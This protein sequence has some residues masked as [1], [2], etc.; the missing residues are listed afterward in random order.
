MNSD[1]KNRVCP[2]EFAGGLDI[3]IR[4]LFHDPMRILRPY[5]SEGMAVLDL[6]CGPGFF[7]MDM[8]K[9]TGVS[10]KV[11]AADLQD[12][13]LEMLKRKIKCAGLKNIEPYKTPKGRIG[14]AEKFDFI[15]IFYVLHEIP[16]QMALLKE[17]K[18]MLKPDGK[19]L[20]VE[21][22]VHV[23]KKD[24]N[25]SIGTMKDIGFNIIEE[26]KIWFSRSV[27]VSNNILT[28]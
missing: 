16:D 24:F 8:A 6:G 18:T 5:I 4:R 25:V 2:I 13:M 7:T 10:G 17:I 27:V 26:P 3:G 12:G 21:P 28:P 15:L 23:S 11:V 14:L 22:K 19:V 20:I 1:N 9:L